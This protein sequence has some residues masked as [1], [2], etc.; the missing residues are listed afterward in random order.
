MKIYTKKGDKGE[1]GLF[2]G[3]RL[4]KAHMRIHSYGTVDEL[5]S[6]IGLVRDHLEDEQLRSELKG[7]QV[8]LFTIGS[9]LATDPSKKNLSLPEINSSAIEA[10]ETNIDKMQQEL[11]ELKSFILPGGHP[12]VSNCHIARCVC[13]RAERYAVALSESEEV[14]PVIIIYLNRLSDYLFVLAR[15]I[16]CMNGVEEVKWESR[17]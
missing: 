1:T 2:G 16:G 12:T 15:H 14:N 6:H 3:A 17:L 13:R 10:L 9:H 4:S 7:I 11:P 5:N 8:T